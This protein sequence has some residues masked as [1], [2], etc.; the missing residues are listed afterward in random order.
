[1]ASKR[2]RDDLSEADVDRFVNLIQQNPPLYDK[3][4]PTYKD[5]DVTT[6]MWLSI[7]EAMNIAGTSGNK[8]VDL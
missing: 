1:M 5:L 8:N 4:E 6:N 3:R 2:K 7:H